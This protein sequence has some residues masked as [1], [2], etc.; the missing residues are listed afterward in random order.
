MNFNSLKL[1]QLM[2]M[3]LLL[4]LISLS[5]SYGKQIKTVP[6]DQ[7]L[8]IKNIEDQISF[9]PL[10]GKY[11]MDDILSQYHN[12]D[13]IDYSQLE[14]PEGESTIWFSV[15]LENTSNQSMELFLGTS[16]FDYLEIYVPTEKALD[17]FKGGI[18]E[19]NT[20]K[21][22]KKGC[23]SFGKIDL[24]AS[25]QKR[26]FMKGTYVD[27]KYFQFS[28]LPFTIY[29]SESFHELQDPQDMFHYLFIGAMLIMT[30]YNL[31]LFMIVK[32]KTYLFYVGYNI[33]ITVYCLGLSGFI[34][35]KGLSSAALQ[36][37][38]INIPGALAFIFYV[39]FSESFLKFKTH[40]PKMSKALKYAQIGIAISLLLFVLGFRN[41]SIAYNFLGAGL[42]YALVIITAYRISKISVSGRYFFIAGLFYIV[43][44]GISIL[45]MLEILPPYLWL[46][47]S[48]N[49]TEMGVIWELALFSLGLGERINEARKAVLRKEEEKKEL[50]EAQNRE[51]E[52][53]VRDR[54]FRLEEMN[55]ELATTNEELHCTME[56]VYEQNQVIE[57][58]NEN[59]TQSINY[60]KRIQSAIMPSEDYL[61]KYLREH[62][63]FFRPKD[64]VS[65][66]FYWATHLGNKAEF[67]LAVVDCTGHGVPGG[68][69]SMLGSELLRDVIEH[70]KIT[71]P[72]EVLQHMNEGIEQSL[73]QSDSQNKDGMD[74][75]LL[76]INLKERKIHYAGA[77]RPL[78]IVRKNGEVEVIRGAKLS[79]GGMTRKGSDEYVTSVVEAEFGDKF[80]IFSDGYPDQIGGP[81][82]RKFMNKRFRALLKDISHLS[83]Q[84]QS[85]IL[86]ETLKEWTSTFRYG[87]IDDIVVMGF[88][89]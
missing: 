39:F 40:Y 45:Q 72:G 1:K 56:T 18:L 11:K 42:G 50:I 66:D 74:M 73:K 25:S 15:V 47:S 9:L 82:K 35:E 81:D 32:D 86:D 37:D 16:L 78:V 80:Y 27:G 52:Q 3:F 6:I 44:I 29:A 57:K 55:S 87:Q 24:P 71:D 34:V 33:T 43:A 84:K 61:S 22:Y 62:F 30:F 38:L 46:F 5:T 89:I 14:F 53:K 65:G 59:I 48:A 63:V 51:L 60:A 41:I 58:K 7:H 13:F 19:L 67:F 28:A 83:M 20:N 49:I 2:V 68:F 31:F 26:I 70:R 64:I 36:E 54:T 8:N 75:S 10:D 23:F 76:R 21:E 69:M 12:D 85:K 17:I 88:E 4:N 79:I 77:K